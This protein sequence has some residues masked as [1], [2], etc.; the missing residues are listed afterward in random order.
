MKISNFPLAASIGSIPLPRHRLAADANINWEIASTSPVTV[1]ILIGGIILI[2]AMVLFALIRYAGKLGP[3]DFRKMNIIGDESHNLDNDITEKDKQLQKNSLVITERMGLRLTNI[4]M[5]YN[6]C[7]LTIK[8]LVLAVSRPLERSAFENHFTTVLM[9]EKRDAYVENLLRF[10]EDEYT[11]VFNSIPP[12]S[13]INEDK[14][15]AW[16]TICPEMKKFLLLW[17]EHNITETIKTCIRKIEIYRQ[18]EPTFKDNL[19]MSEI[20]LKRMQ[21][22]DDYIKKLDRHGKGWTEEEAP[23]SW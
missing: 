21:K 1:A 7:P 5:K 22:N 4:F 10:I 3:V 23:Q 20:I 18:K 16:V 15:P 11:A 13:C 19:R 14:M 9:P 12:V 17:V 6:M 8:T 2:I